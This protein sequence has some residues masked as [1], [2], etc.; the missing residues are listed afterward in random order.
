VTRTTT[1]RLIIEK[2]PN[3]NRRKRLALKPKME[4]ERSLLAFLAIFEEIDALKW[5]LKSEKTASSKKRKT[6]SLLFSLY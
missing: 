3:L 4:P 6:E 1:T 5:K 2:F